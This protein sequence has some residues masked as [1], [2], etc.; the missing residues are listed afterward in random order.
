MESSNSEKDFHGFG[1]DVVLPRRLVLE[2]AG[3]GEDEYLVSVSREQVT[4]KRGR[5]KGVRGS[6]DTCGGGAIR[7]ENIINERRR[8]SAVLENALSSPST[9]LAPENTPTTS[10]L[11]SSVTGTSTRQKMYMLDK[12]DTRFKFSKLPKAK[13]VLN[14][15]LLQLNNSSDTFTAAK[16]TITQLKEVWAYHFGRRIIQGYDQDMQE[17]SKKMISEDFNIR[18]KILNLW[19]QWKEMERTSRRKDR[20]ATPSFLERQ[21]KFDQEVLDMPF[22][23]LAEG[24][25]E[26]LQHE[27]GIKD[28]KEDLQH[29]HNQLLRDQIDTCDSRDFKQK[30]RDNRKVREKQSEEEAQK[31]QEE[32]EKAKKMQHSPMDDIEEVDDKDLDEN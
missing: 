24:Y 9:S 26:I 13:T 30:K 28:W 20:C 2:V 19:E 27:S 8:N 17:N 7:T 23:I 25:A 18:R 31:K 14:I 16:E 21:V 29:L 32:E 4:R 12:V 10:S 1:S 22:N 5:G 15:F 6:L 3:E 11:P